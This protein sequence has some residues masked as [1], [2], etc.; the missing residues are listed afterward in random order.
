[1]PFRDPLVAGT[2][3]V[4][5]EIRSPDWESGTAGWCIR[6]DGTAELNNAIIGGYITAKS[7]QSAIFG[8]RVQIIRSENPRLISFWSQ[9]DKFSDLRTANIEGVNN[10]LVITVP[11]YVPNGGLTLSAPTVNLGSALGDSSQEIKSNSIYY[12]TATFSANL[13]MASNP[14]GV[15]YRVASSQ[16]YKVNIETAQ[17]NQLVADAL[18]LRPVTYYDKAQVEENEGDITGLSQQMGLIAEDVA[19]LPALGQ[20]LSETDSGG[21]PE[22]VNYDRVGV[23]LIPLIKHLEKRITELEKRVTELGG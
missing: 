1:M 22:S 7:F 16:R 6:Q 23:A 5:A 2:V 18:N 3:L 19:Q 8:E 14:Q 4:R 15:I 12:R 10:G 9:P 17:S 13:G 21:Q 11:N 20:L